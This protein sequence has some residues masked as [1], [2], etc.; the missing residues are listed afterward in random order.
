MA[1]NR[2]TNG[3]AVRLA[4]VV[5]A[6]LL[7]LFLGGSGIGYVWQKGQIDAL[8]RQIGEREKR[9]A[10]LRRQNKMRS[11][12]LAALCSPT[13]LEAK[14]KA[15]NLGLVQPPISQ[16]VRL[17]E[18]AGE[19]AAAAAPQQFAEQRKTEGLP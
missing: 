5:N 1:R 9:L 18:S 2:K 8:G 13:A 19:P 7:C 10:D 11:D 4:P 3:G 6:F 17:V 12:H 15:L 14:V 16:V